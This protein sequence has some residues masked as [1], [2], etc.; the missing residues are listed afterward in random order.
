MNE[1]KAANAGTKSREIARRRMH[2]QRLWG[3]PLE[4][5]EEV[6]R[7]MAALQAQ[8]YP[9]AKWS[10]AQR[11]SGVSD[12]AMDRAFADGEI[13]RTHILRP[14][15]HFVVPG[16]LRW[17]MD[18]SGPRVNALNAHYYRKLELD[19]EL[20]GRSNALLSGALEGGRQLTRKEIAAVLDRGG[21]SA[22]GL[23]LAYVL[24]RAE[25]D[26]VICS[27]AMRGKQH[28]YAL[29]DD[30]VP[31][32]K[33]LQ[34]DEALAELTRRYFSA[35]GPA[36]LKDYVR[37]SSVTTADARR[38]LAMVE[39][40]LEQEV[41]DG[42]TYWFAASPPRAKAASTLIDLV[43]GYDEC[44]MSYSESKDVLLQPF[45]TAAPRET[46]VFTHAI[47]LDGRLIGHWRPV[48]GKNGVTVETSLYRP[49]DRVDAQALDGGVE[50]YGRFLGV[51]A[52]IGQTSATRPT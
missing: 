49:L 24:M 48:H 21:I 10:V 39:S 18:L 45:A 12:A 5:P 9:V 7:W 8:E 4:T 27:G 33:S 43:Q 40:R 20:L 28:T 38:G 47:L 52:K 14:T 19:D 25:L 22:T 6:V 37:W 13:L 35:R 2:S 11:A 42:R 17:M 31:Q 32:A 50:R 15:W 3:I 23:R 34:R 51:S 29:F 44:I 41:V 26:T 36:T 1:R 16:D 30:R 46:V